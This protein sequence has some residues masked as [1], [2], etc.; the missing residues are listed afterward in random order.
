MPAF[1]SPRPVSEGEEG[2][3][4]GLNDLARG[5]CALGLGMMLVVAL[6]P[7]PC[8][9]HAQPDPSNSFHDWSSVV[10]AADWRDGQGQP[11]E[12]FDNARRDLSRSLLSLGFSPQHH[13]SLTLNPVKP[14]R[15]TPIQALERIGSVSTP[16]RTGCLFYLTSHGSPANI[17]FGD[18]RGLE[19]AHLSTFLRQWCGPRPTVVILSAC[20]AGS[21]VDALKA[22]N[23]L[24]MTAARRD[25]S[26]FGCGPG[27]TYP[28]Y[29]ACILQ[30]LPEAAHFLDLATRTRDCVTQKET[31]AEI[32]IPSEPQVFIGAEMQ[33]R[34]PLLRFTNGP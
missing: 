3:R 10:I 8:Q 34:L 31:E 32:T 30:N 1:D 33:M 13:A 17:V 26:S 23:R 28:W 20:F 9:A 18:T 16:A 15:V 29:D 12:A 25:R 24:I 7:L 4:S 5:L 6:P 19:P 27:E 22:P 14:D 2:V 11:I 21:F